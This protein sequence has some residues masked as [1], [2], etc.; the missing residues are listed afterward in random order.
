MWV[1][2]AEKAHNE[3]KG[4]HMV[5]DL[6]AHAIRNEDYSLLVLIEFLHREKGTISLSDP[7]QCLEKYL[8]PK[9]KVKMNNLIAE[10]LDS[11]KSIYANLI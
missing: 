3:T 5:K 7:I 4:I 8:L 2:E 1:K 11:G 6:L 10:F 9:H